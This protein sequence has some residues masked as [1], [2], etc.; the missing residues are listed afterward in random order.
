ME[1][2]GKQ[3]EDTQL[4]IR[5]SHIEEPA[6]VVEYKTESVPLGSFVDSAQRT[7]LYMSGA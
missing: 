1:I 5:S 4:H 6:P 3:R 7:V 2:V